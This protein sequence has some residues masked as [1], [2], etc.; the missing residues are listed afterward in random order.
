MEFQSILYADTG[1]EVVQAAPVYFQDLHLDYLLTIIERAVKDYAVRPHY[2]TLPASMEVVRYRQEVFSDL[3]QKCLSD[4]VQKFCLQMQKSRRAH[5]LAHESGETV[6]AASYHLEAAFLY[7]NGLVGF[8]SELAACELSS[9]GF[10]SLREELERTIAGWREEGFEKALERAHGLFSRIR[11]QFVVGRENI[12]IEELSGAKEEGGT[13]ASAEVKGTD[14]TGKNYFQ[15]L[16]ELLSLEPEETKGYMEGIFP[17]A[18]EPSYLEMT[19]VQILRKNNPGIFKEIMGFY[20]TYPDFY[21]EK[22][23]RF[24]EE[25]QFY[26]S[27]LEFKENTE[28]LGYPL[29]VP[30]WTEDGTFSG[31]GMYDLAL[32]WKNANRGYT[33]VSNDFRYPDEPSFF[34]VTGPNQGGKTTFAR[35]M[36]QAVYL[37]LMGLYV[38]AETFVYP[39]FEGISTHFEVEE[40]IQSNSGKLKD[41]I[42]RLAPMMQQD[43]RRH[44]IVLNELFTTATTYDALIMGKK[45]MDHFL[46]KECHGIYVTHIQELAEETDSVVSLVAQVE[47]GGDDRRTYRMLRT[48][49]RGYGYSDSLVRKFELRYEDLMRRLP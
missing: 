42:D 8:G 9:G 7:W 36:G 16:A 46:Q 23:L 21:S 15:E 45:V 5:E 49:A 35:S 33:V 14:V 39:W 38:N 43:R 28:K 37:A 34:V 25:V 1:P 32:V 17:N 13:G 11:F 48:E 41:E 10:L 40:K 18:L 6:Q 26:I 3:R 4:C 30:H 22:I 24:E 44:F 29:R 47:P 27:F 20:Q 19:L 2:Y 12:T 31:T